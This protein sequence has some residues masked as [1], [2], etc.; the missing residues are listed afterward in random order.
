MDDRDYTIRDLEGALREARHRAEDLARSKRLLLR[1]VHELL[2]AM[3]E[4]CEAMP[5][6]EIEHTG[7]HDYRCD[8]APGPVNPTYVNAER[9]F[10]EHWREENKRRPGVNCGL[11]S[12]ELLLN[13][14]LGHE[15]QCPE[16]TQRDATVAATVI[17]WLG[18]SCG[19]GFLDAVE[20]EYR[21]ERDRAVAEQENGHD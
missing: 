18:T 11:G 12:L 3:Q 14:V 4:Q 15:V 5:Y 21:K 6:P 19:N 1:T 20:Q 16:I 10:R 2:R 9:L 7:V 8:Y 13:P 17:Q